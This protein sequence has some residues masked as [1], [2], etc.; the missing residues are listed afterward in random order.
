MILEMQY[1]SLQ[2]YVRENCKIENIHYI[3]IWRSIF[4][5]EAVGVTDYFNILYL[6]ELCLTFVVANA[7]SETGLSHTKRVENN[8]RSQ[9][10]KE[11]LFSLMRM[12]MDVTPY[13]EYSLTKTEEVFLT[14]KS[15]ARPEH[16]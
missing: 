7:K 13:T 15:I 5:L 11:P 14:K 2:D 4:C 12:A 8:Y 3:A 9:L 1:R 16:Q 10:G 6:A